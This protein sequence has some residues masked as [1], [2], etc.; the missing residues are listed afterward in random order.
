MLSISDDNLREL[1]GDQD[2]SPFPKIN[3]M[4]E[5]HHLNFVGRTVHY[6]Q[7]SYAVTR[8]S[9]FAKILPAFLMK[10]VKNIKLMMIE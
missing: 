9:L 5:L 3:E 6:R 1:E 8:Y 10:E 4:K 2:Y 7:L